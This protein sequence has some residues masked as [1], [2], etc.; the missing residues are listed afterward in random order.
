MMRK[1]SPMIILMALLL[2]AVC[3][4]CAF[5]DPQTNAQPFS[6]T[7]EPL[8]DDLAPDEKQTISVFERV[9][10]SVVFITASTRRAFSFNVQDIPRGSGSGFVWDKKGHIVT[11]YHVVEP[12]IQSR[13]GK[14]TVVLSDHT[15]YQAQVVGYEMD[16]DLAVVRIEAPT[17]KLVP[18]TV[19]TSDN[20]RVGQRVM[21]IGNPFGLDLT[22][23]TGVV[24]ALGREISALSGRK[25]YDMIQTDAAINPGN[26]GGP[27][28][29]S[30]GRLVG[31]NTAILS[32]SGSYAGIGFATPVDMVRRIVP[33]LV[34]HGVVSWPGLGIRTI[35]DSRRKLDGVVIGS[36]EEGGAADRAGLRG[37]VVDYSTRNVMQ[38]GD[39]IT[40]IG[41]NRVKTLNDLLDALERFDVGEEVEIVFIRNER[42]RQKTVAKLDPVRRR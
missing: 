25:I 1:I 34:K 13:G 39:I 6:R 3:G 31:M 16:K 23:T 12:V 8:P 41:G 21:A 15:S 35:P 10:D 30:R 42:E 40:E 22:L 17:N 5:P 9:S 37:T 36:V 33:Q 27:L 32:P 11:N 26:S 14:L 38:W 18:V 20:L 2:G 19:G 4:R 29:D 24:S 28:L 7:P